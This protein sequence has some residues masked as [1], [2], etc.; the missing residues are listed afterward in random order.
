MSSESFVPKPG[1]QTAGESGYSDRSSSRFVATPYCSDD[2]PPTDHPLPAPSAEDPPKVSFEDLAVRYRQNQ[3][4]QTRR[5]RLEYRLHATKVSMGISARLVRVG[6]AV[7]RGLVD[8]LKH[9]DKANFI[10]L[11]HTMIDLQESCDSAFRRHFHRQDPLEDWP[12]SPEA[13]VDRAPDFFLQLSPQSRADLIGILQSVRTDPQFIF[14]R[15][16]SLTPGQLSALVASS[17]P[18]WETS[19]LSFPSASRSR[20]PSFPKRNPAPSIPFRDHV[21]AFERTDP[22]STL[23]FNVFAAPLESDAPEARL[24]LDVWSSVCAKLV[25]DGGSRYYHLIGNI[26]AAWATGSDWKAKPKFELYLMDILQTGAFLLEHVEPPSGLSFDAEPI[27]PLKTDVAE[28]FFVS[29]VDG[30]FHLLD[31]PDGGLPHAVMELSKAV[32]QKLDRQESRDRF[33]EFLFVQWFFSKFLYGALT[34]PEVCYHN[35]GLLS[36]RI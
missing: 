33:L 21:L 8:R 16:C 36:P 2:G 7:Q 22:L 3:H 31:D 23:L 10:A 28:E 34:Y 25:A 11:Y 19:D 15:L 32:L 6:A 18:S 12:S 27:D 1:T 4:K 20:N 26:L 30:L 5:K 14:E 13:T 35:F 9:D 29:A 24:R 17:A